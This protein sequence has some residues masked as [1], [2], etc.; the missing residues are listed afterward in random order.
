MI[1]YNTVRKNKTLAQ[2]LEPVEEKEPEEA[3]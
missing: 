1:S 3:D 2:V